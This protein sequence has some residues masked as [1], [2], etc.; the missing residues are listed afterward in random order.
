MTL[1]TPPAAKEQVSNLLGGGQAAASAGTRCLP[2]S[3]GFRTASPEKG[4]LGRPPSSGRKG[5][6]QTAKLLGGEGQ[7]F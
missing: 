7:L 2:F 4:M 5:L 6:E 3:S 1:P